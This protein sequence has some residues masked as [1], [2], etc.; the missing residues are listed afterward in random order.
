MRVV[1][2]IRPR[3]NDEL[4]KDLWVLKSNFLSS[5]FKSQSYV[6]K[7]TVEDFIFE[8]TDHRGSIQVTAKSNDPDLIKK[9]YELSD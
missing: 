5:K 8:K 9:V 4:I 1:L 7:Q 6:L 2:E 3:K